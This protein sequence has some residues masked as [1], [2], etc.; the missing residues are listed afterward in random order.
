MP[1]LYLGF[2]LYLSLFFAKPVIGQISY[3][4]F[5]NNK[6]KLGIPFELKGHLIIV[7]IVLEEKLPLNFILDTGSPFSVLFEKTYADIL[8][9]KYSDTIRLAGADQTRAL[10]GHIARRIKIGLSPGH[11]AV[12]DIII[13]SQDYFKLKNYIGY[14]I[15]GILGMD[16]FKAL[17]VE[18]NF[19]RQRVVFYRDSTAI[20][21]S[22]K[23]I[24][25]PIA[26]HNGKPYL[27]LPLK[28]D[29][30]SNSLV[31]ANLLLDT[32][33]GLNMLLI[34]G[35]SPTIQLPKNHI[36]GFI[37]TGLGGNVEGYLSRIEGYELG[38]VTYHR[39][40]AYFQSI[41]SNV[42]RLDTSFVRHG[43]IGNKLLENYSVIID[44][45]HNKL[46]LKPYH[47]KPITFNWDKSGLLVY[48]VGAD[49]NHFIIG[50]VLEHS[51]AAKAGILPG[52]QI[53]RIGWWPASW[54][55]LNR[56]T[57]MLSGKENSKI[58]LTIN[59]NGTIIK[60]QFRLKKLI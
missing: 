33:A 4:D 53:V 43:I 60:K 47:T 16:F 27:R 41:D 19:R 11:T 52:D 59:R 32:G 5:L 3:H 12:R 17:L 35:S 23:Y 6:D 56:I 49:F 55:S 13:L 9:I 20:H 57:K 2:I 42:V 34:N 31:E 15:H 28:V 46:F 10:R 39:T 58:R 1:Q 45:H 37:G 14:N 24:Q 7:H 22:R 8:R 26:T 50:D 25:I 40:L 29:A 44:V 36:R 54:F 51:P 48:A 30:D 38:G 18:I 21:I